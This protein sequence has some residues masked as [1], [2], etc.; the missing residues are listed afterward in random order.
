MWG[1]RLRLRLALRLVLRGVSGILRL[2]GLLL[3]RLEG[4]LLLRLRLLL[5]RLLSRK[6]S[7]LWLELSRGESGSLRLELRLRASER[8]RLAC[9]TGRLRRKA[10]RLGLLHWWLLLTVGELRV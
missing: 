10:C 1:L 6:A 5:L 2:E 4:L 3:L 7:E 9:E 8:R